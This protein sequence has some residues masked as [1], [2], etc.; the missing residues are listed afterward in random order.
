MCMRLTRR[1]AAY[2]L[3]TMHM[4]Y[5]RVKTL[6]ARP[7]RTREGVQ[8]E[9]DSYARGCDLG[10]TTECVHTQEHEKH[11]ATSGSCMTRRLFLAGMGSV[12]CCCGCNNACRVRIRSVLGHAWRYGRRAACLQR[13]RHG[14]LGARWDAAHRHGSRLTA[15]NWQEDAPS[16]ENIPIEN[17]AG[18]YANGYDVWIASRIAEG[19]GLTPTAVKMEFN[20]LISALNNGQI[21][22]IMAGMAPTEERRQSINFS[23]FYSPQI[24]YVVLVMAG[25]PYASATHLRISLGNDSWTV[26]DHA[27]YRHHQIPASTMPRRLIAPPICLRAL[28]TA[29]VDGITSDYYGALGFVRTNSNLVMVQFDEGKGFELE[30]PGSSAGIRKA[31]TDLLDR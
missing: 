7:G 11:G 17:V 22:I 15:Y 8:H 28:R 6:L 4:R 26:A 13:R 14:E 9:K 16:D 5:R 10:Y 3:D 31:D 30:R 20:G 2:A 12:S 21:D 29:T 23:E 24:E 27:R 1:L 19:L 18:A 25:S